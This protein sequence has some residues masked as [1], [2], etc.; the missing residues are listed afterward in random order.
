MTNEKIQDTCLAVLAGGD[1][2]RLG[3]YKPLIQL[4]DRKLVEYVLDNLARYFN[5]VLLVVKNTAHRNWL[6]NHIGGV[7]NKYGVEILLDKANVE[8]PI[9]G[10]MTA[11]EHCVNDYL[12]IAPSDTPFINFN[13]YKRLRSYIIEQKYDAALPVWPNNYVEPLVSY[14]LRDKLIRVITEKINSDEL[15]VQDIYR[16][17]NTAFVDVHS[18]SENPS[19]DF[20]NINDYKDLDLALKILIKRG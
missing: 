2:S 18:L 16:S 4:G 13:I 3:F 5:E 9:A 7:I 19:L 11:A 10:I 15:R 8:G 17:L 6:L 1:G 12:A 20:L 14:N